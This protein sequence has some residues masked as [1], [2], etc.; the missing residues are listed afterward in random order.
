MRALQFTGFGPPSVMDVAD[1]PAPHAGPG[2]IRIAVRASGLSA[3]ETLIRSGALK[4]QIPLPYRTGFDAA[5]IVDEVGPG[6]NGVDIGDDVFGWV[7]MSRRGA[8]ADLAVLV[9]WAPR[10]AAWSWPE[11]GGAAGTVETGTRVLDRLALGEGETVLINGAS[12]GVGT[13]A[14]QLAIARGLNVIGTASE[15]NHDLL[16]SLGATPATYGPGLPDRVRGVDAVF[17]CAGGAL[18]DLIAI[19]G[20]PSRVV[21]IADLTAADHGV[22]LS[23][24]LS[25]PLAAHALPI[26]VGLANEGRLRVPVEAAFALEDAPAAHTLSESRRARGKIVFV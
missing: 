14:V 7:A 15:R 16:R 26:A 25:D 4:I 12:G 5:G 23:S 18:P 1:V 3:G 19:A 9:A 20:D 6:V 8:N 17:D 13:V 11:A 10:P 24:G 21:T 22:H 2:E